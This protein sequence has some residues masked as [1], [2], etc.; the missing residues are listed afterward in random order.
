MKL[1]DEEIKLLIDTHNVFIDGDMYNVRD[2]EHGWEYIPRMWY[3][4]V[5]AVRLISEFKSQC[6]DDEILDLSDAE[7]LG[8][9]IFESKLDIEE[10]TGMKITDDDLHE[11]FE[12]IHEY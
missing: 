11:L 3:L 6:A 4:E 12:L 8:I 7:G 1:S 2:Q 5:I 10:E 9:L